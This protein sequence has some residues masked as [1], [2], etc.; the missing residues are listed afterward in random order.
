ML[1]QAGIIN[2]QITGR[3]PGV[4]DRQAVCDRVEE[5]VVQVDLR[6]HSPLCLE[7]LQ[8]QEQIDNCSVRGIRK[9]KRRDG[10]H[11]R[12]MMVNNSRIA[13]VQVLSDYNQSFCL[14]RL[15]LLTLENDFILFSYVQYIRYLQIIGVLCVLK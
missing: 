9:V 15:F 10:K 6:D 1:N 8:R 5:K 12:N 7:F 14:A 13:L 3:V 11:K 4:V 2:L